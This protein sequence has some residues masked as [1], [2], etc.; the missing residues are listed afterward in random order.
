MTALHSVAPIHAYSAGARSYPISR[1]RTVFA[2]QRIERPIGIRNQPNPA[3][4]AQQ[5][6]IIRRNLTGIHDILRGFE[7]PCRVADES[8]HTE[9]S[10]NRRR[11][12][13]TKEFQIW[14]ELGFFEQRSDF[15]NNGGEEVSPVSTS[16]AV[17][18]IEYLE[19]SYRP[20]CGY[21]DGELLERTHAYKP[22]RRIAFATR[23]T[24]TI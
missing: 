10:W 21:L 23:S 15:G 9:I 11:D 20:D 6:R 7:D 14:L 19:T 13:T 2:Q 1:P 22:R 12:F 5:N 18:L 17:M 24:A 8:V 3:F 16:T 4:G